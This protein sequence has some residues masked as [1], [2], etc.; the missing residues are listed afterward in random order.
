M[1]VPRRCGARTPGPHR[2]RDNCPRP[3]ARR[4]VKSRT[5]VTAGGRSARRSIQSLVTRESEGRNL[6]GC[7]DSNSGPGAPLA[8]RAILDDRTGDRVVLVRARCRYVWSLAVLLV[9]L[10]E[11]RTVFGVD[12]GWIACVEPD[13]DRPAG[14]DLG[15]RERCEM[16]A[17]DDVEVSSI[18]LVRS[19]RMVLRRP[20]VRVPRVYA[21]FPLRAA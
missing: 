11:R 2:T 14:L 17:G 8:E 4:G 1:A 10:R 19:P 5:T 3:A 20:H 6:V 7:R 9:H 16:L 18:A 12:V 15:F 13:R 21:L